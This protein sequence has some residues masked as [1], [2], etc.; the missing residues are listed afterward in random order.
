MKNF[1]F[2]LIIKLAGTGIYAYICIE[3]KTKN[4]YDTKRITRL[5]EF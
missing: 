1:L 4:N 5:K 3:I 2:F